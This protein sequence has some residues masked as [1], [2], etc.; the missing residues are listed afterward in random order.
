MSDT[1]NVPT[2]KDADTKTPMMPEK[3]SSPKLPNEEK[4]SLYRKQDGTGSMSSK[5]SR[6]ASTDS[7]THL[8]NRR[9]SYRRRSSFDLMH[10]DSLPSLPSLQDTVKLQE[11]DLKSVPWWT[12]Y[13]FRYAIIWFLGF[14]CLYAQRVNLS[15]AIV[16]M[17]DHKYFEELL[18][19]STASDNPTTD[20]SEK[21]GHNLTSLN[22]SAVA[23]EDTCPVNL[24][25]KLKG[26]FRWDKPLQ[27][28]LLGA[29]FWGYMVLQ[30]PGGRLAERFGAKKVIAISMFPVSLINILS[31]VLA[32]WNPYAFL[33]GR[34]IIGMG[35]GVMYPAAQAFWSKWSPPNERSRLIGLSYAGGQFG[36][37]IIFPIGGFLCAYGFDNGWGSV[38]YVIGVAG[39]IWCVAW[40]IFIHDSPAECPKI[41]DIERKYIESSI[42]TK[43]HR[44][45]GQ[46]TPWKAIFSSRAVWAIIIAHM[47]GN[48]GAYMLL[49]QIPTYM[50]E[51]LKFDIKANGVFSM[52][53]YLCFWFFIVVSGTCADLLI[54][55]NI[56]SV[57]WTR[58]LMSAI[59][60]I[61][62]GSFLIGTGF[63]NCHQQIPAVVMLTAAV[64]L[65]GFHFSGYFI[66][67]GDVAPAYA[68]TLFGI[69]NAAA[70]IPG[71]IAPYIVGA[72]TPNGSQKEW[73][74]V[75][76][77]AVGVYFFGAVY[78][79]IMGVGEVQEWSMATE[80]QEEKEE[81]EIQFG[82]HNID[83]ELKEENESDLDEADVKLVN[84]GR[85]EAEQ[86][87]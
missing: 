74:L 84:N 14:V 12:S 60:T 61:G 9:A 5:L 16:T 41:S 37:A 87:V 20:Y 35:E 10:T 69:T 57:A 19:N 53:P 71:V 58:K 31:P 68:G 59:G 51:V 85:N 81:G 3:P 78:Y 24:G 55:R 18:A 50:K 45:K 77:I 23:D 82:L 75:F 56:L 52:L 11:I 43:A 48:Y 6:Q 28:L 62:P 13:R 49:T 73:Q 27:G 32:R 42:G 25:E 2:D 79:A 40:C 15:I 39:F 44:S 30:V 83:E 65:C 1:P 46:A 26:E 64:G 86:K 29:F 70:T 54:S 36:N 63:M 76:Y 4:K 47:C 80:D 38:F 72:L 67:H 66:N 34:V 21:D 33:V 17:V 7:A 22:V 8:A